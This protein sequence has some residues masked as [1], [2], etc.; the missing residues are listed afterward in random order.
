MKPLR[1]LSV[2]FRNLPP[3]KVLFSIVL[4]CT[5][6]LGGGLPSAVYGDTAEELQQK[7]ADRNAKIAELERDITK[8]ENDLSTIG[9]QKKT[10]EG[11]VSRLD[12]SRKKIGTDIAVTENRVQTAE[13]ELEE[14]DG[15]ID[16]K[17]SRIENGKAAIGE[18]LEGLYRLGDTTLVEQLLATGGLAEAWEEHDKLRQLDAS[19]QNNITE[20]EEVK[21]SLTIDYRAVQDRQAKL[22]SYKR[23]LSG[24][25]TLL[26]QNRKEQVTLLSQTKNKESEYQKLLQEKQAAKTTFE[27]ELRDFEAALQYNYD[28]SKIPA[29]GS[30]ALK[31]PL[32]PSFMERCKTRQSTFGNIYC[33]TQ[34][35]GNTPF[36]RTG[37]YNGKG[38]NGIDFGAP[39][40]TKI[41]AALSGVVIG[42]GNTDI[43]RGCYSYGKWVLVQHA[44]G[45]TTVYGHMS[46]VSVIP[47]DV[48]PT[49]GLLGYSGKT[50]YATGPHLHLSVFASDAVKLTHYG[51]VRPTSKCAPATIPIAPTEGYLNPMVY[52]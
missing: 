20:L 15:E 18:S 11:E 45:L 50:G 1:A 40:G 22:V 2:L 14:L 17:Q 9:S 49:G 43:Y 21:E 32:D 39:E 8:Y 25:K 12:I 7:I 13:L 34:Y 38:H 23:E 51:D 41:V 46:L 10:L 5:L 35:F 30:G 6:A 19:I 24:Q 28:P 36:A 48:V 3:A 33:I 47:G 4:L 16:D 31:F 37:A 52:L 26:D 42:T 44:N 27:Q 29:A